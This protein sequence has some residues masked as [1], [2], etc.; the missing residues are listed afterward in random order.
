MLPHWDTVIKP[1]LIALDRGPI[2]EIG[3]ATGAT[4]SKLLELAQ[5][6][7]LVLHTI[8][9]APDFDVAGFE[10]RFGRHFK[11][12]RARSHDVLS[13]IGLP[14]AAIIDGD[15]NWYTVHGELML[16]NKLAAEQSGPF[17][18]VMLHDVEGPYARRDMYY[19]P[20]AIPEEWRKPWA[21]RGIVAGE[22]DLADDGRGG[23]AQ[24]ANALKAGGPRN[25]VLTAVEDFIA[26]RAEPLE[27][28][29]VHG[30]CGIGVLVSSDLLIS[31]QHVRMRWEEL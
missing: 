19:E 20:E 30:K 25:G 12:H 27:L 15:H 3:A 28:R 29:I 24:F 17:P 11:F 18:L 10:Q 21:R 13:D 31:S 6:K 9:P 7:N 1:M 4:T 26:G 23:N 8:D 16:L 5:C 2:V 22:R 14:A